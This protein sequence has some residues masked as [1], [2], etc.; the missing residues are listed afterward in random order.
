MSTSD[1]CNGTSKSNNDGVCEVNDMLQNMSTADKDI[2]SICANCGKEGDDINNTCNKCKM[3]KYC[4][5]SCKKK[6]RHKHKKDCEDH[7]KLATEHAAK[8]HDEELFKQPPPDEDCP[9]CFLLLPSLDP[10]GKKY[11]TCCGKMICSGCSHAPVYDNQ[12]NVVD[13]KKCPF[14]RIPTPNTQEKAIEREKKRMELNDA[15]AIYRLGVYH[16]DGLH[17]FP[18]DYTKALELYHRAGELGN[19]QG[20]NAIGIAHYRGEGVQIDEEKARHYLELAAMGGE[21]QARFNLGNK[22]GKAGNF[23]RAL[24]H[25]MIAVRS[26]FADSLKI[27]K[28]LYTRGHA[29]KEDYMKALQL[30]QAYLSEIKSDQR[31]KAAAYNNEEYRYY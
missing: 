18:Q 13:N 4:N 8:L 12:G 28:E 19:A 11:K 10:T 7:V 16:R 21:A 17:G 9:I 6:H 24:K 26:G 2:I 31:D 29:T 30:Y 14:C 27:I 20:Y 15:H 3:V 23:D 25:H 22:E 5:A 1:S